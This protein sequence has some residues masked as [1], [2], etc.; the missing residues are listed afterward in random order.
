MGF[1][2]LRYRV[3]TGFEA[4]QSPIQWVPG[5]LSLGVKRPGREADQ[6][7]PS[8]VKVKKGWSYTFTLPT[9]PQAWCLVKYRDNFTFTFNIVR[10]VKSTV[11]WWNGNVVWL[12]RQEM[13]TQIWCETSL[14]TFM[15]LITAVSPPPAHG[16]RSRMS[17]THSLSCVNAN[18]T[19][20]YAPPSYKRGSVSR[21]MAV[22]ILPLVGEE[23][24]P[25]GWIMT[26]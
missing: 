26:I 22:E 19:C 21:F 24:T 7:P 12:G 20:K 1:F 10:A 14:K 3:Q 15:I 16:A 23:E 4:H 13:Q 8:S 18:L 9:R 25:V 2:S 11:L 17:K 6:S 5:A